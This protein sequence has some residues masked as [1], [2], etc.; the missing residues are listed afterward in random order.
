MGFVLFGGTF[1]VAQVQ[2]VTESTWLPAIW[3]FKWNDGPV[4][5]GPQVMARRAACAAEHVRSL[6]RMGALHIWQAEQDLAVV[7][8]VQA[9]LVAA[10]NKDVGLGFRLEHK[11][12]SSYTANTCFRSPS[13]DRRPSPHRCVQW[14]LQMDGLDTQVLQLSGRTQMFGFV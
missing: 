4:E 10:Y 13:T 8:L 1:C 6:H 14:W 3:N 11:V 2:C 12:G 9:A 5:V 7:N